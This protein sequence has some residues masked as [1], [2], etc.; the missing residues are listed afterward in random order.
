MR[1]LLLA[2]SALWALGL[3][4]CSVVPNANTPSVQNQAQA[5]APDWLSDT[6]PGYV[7]ARAPI[8]GEDQAAAMAA[9][10]QQARVLLAE[11]VRDSLAHYRQQ[12]WRDAQIQ[13]GSL[14]AQLRQRVR[15]SL[16][17]EDWLVVKQEAHYVDSATQE[18][19]VLVSANSDTQR[20]ALQARLEQLDAQLAD[21]KHASYR[22][23]EFTQL[24]ALIPALPTLEER[25]L[26]KAALVQMFG[27]QPPLANE[28]MAY[29]ME[30]Q[31]SALFD[32]FVIGV[33]ALTA[34]AEAF[35]A[36]WVSALKAA[37]LTI[38]A[39]RP[40]LILKYFIEQAR[41]DQTLTLVADVELIHRD[42]SRFATLSDEV[43]V[44]DDD[45][46][47]AQQAALT[48]LAQ[49]INALILQQ[50]MTRIEQHNDVKFSR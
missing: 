22:G 33:D 28:R 13:P 3:S 31:I 50:A 5:L 43:T 37:G 42:S 11:G 12:Q 47:R 23:S 49:A 16:A 8:V 21:Y 10:M 19:A 24:W 9:A 36:D 48:Q 18:V 2:L 4:G 38:S 41:E 17:G 32:S 6:K 20:A 30:R 45:H 34:E 29:L 25:A 35:E 1:P 7:V 44:S 15:D 39:R 27:E 26:V 14:Q 40:S 46:P